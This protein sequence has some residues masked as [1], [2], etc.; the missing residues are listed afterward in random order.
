[1]MGV[2]IAGVRSGCG[3]TSLT[4]GLLRALREE[5]Y[6]VRP[7]KVGPDYI[8]PTYLEVAAGAESYNLDVW[9]MGEG[10]VVDTFRRATRGFTGA[11]VEGVMGMFDGHGEGTVEGSTAHV[12]RLIGAPVVLVVDCRS[13]ATTVAAEVRGF[14]DLAREVGVELAGVI[15]NRVGSERHE[16]LLRRAL[17]RY[18]PGVRVLGVVPRLRDA[19]IPDRHLG[20]IP[21]DERRE[22]AE[23]VAEYWG[24]VASEYLDLDAIAGLEAGEPDAEPVPPPSPPREGVRVAVVSG[25]VFT[26]YYRENLRYLDRA[27]EVVHVDPE[28]DRLPDVDA[29]YV[30]G[31]YPE[32]YAERLDRRLMEDL[33]G[34]HEEGGPILG[35]CGGLMYLCSELVDADG[36]EHEMVGVFDAVARM[37]D[38]LVA[39]GYVKGRITGNHPFGRPGR[40]VRG[41]EF[42]YS[43]VEVREDVEFAYRLERGRG[44]EE[45]RDGLVKGNTVASYT[46]LHVR[47][48]GGVLEGLIRLAS[49]RGGGNPG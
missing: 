27:G 39:L 20:L 17:E 22:F 25:R 30:P 38:R 19:V 9:M 6:R 7:F 42:H 1:V 41:H 10:G 2:V 37:R 21:A 16:R 12:A 8:D 36:R 18:C 23:R 11:V 5:G 46:H 45:G 28:G 3:K 48:D 47:S 33:R 43:E 13:Y 26:F 32:V 40:V 34:F 31:G 15:L 29:V 24:E 4:I 14:L 35:E 49:S 44:I